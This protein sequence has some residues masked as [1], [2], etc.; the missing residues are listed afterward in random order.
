MKVVYKPWGKEEWLELNDHYCY[1][2]IYINA[3]FQTSYQYH[4]EKLETNYIAKGKAEVWLENEDGVVEKSI[5]TE[6]DTFTVIPPRKHRVVAIT[7]IILQEVS[8][9]Q[10]DDIVRLEDDTNRGG[11][12]LESEHI[13]PGVLI[14]AAGKGERLKSLTETINKAL[15][16]I[17]NEAIISKIIKKF[18][19]E[20]KFVITLGYKGKMIEN[21]LKIAFPL[22]DFE[23]V[24]VD[25]F[26]SAN[27]GPGYSAL[28]CKEF[29]QRPFYLVT[30]DCLI[31]SPLPSLSGN[32]LGVHPT[33]Y[34][35]KY[36]TVKFDD[37]FSI[38]EF[39]NKDINGFDY[40]FIGL[41]GFTDYQKFWSELEKN[42]DEGELVNSFNNP[43]KYNDFQAEVLDWFDTGNLD[44]LEKAKLYFRDKPL[45]LS[46]ENNEFVYKEDTKFIKFISHPGRLKNLYNRGLFLDKLIPNNLSVTDSFL[47]YDWVE[48]DTLY[49]ID[50]IEIYKKFIDDYLDSVELVPG[51][52]KDNNYFYKDKTFDRIKKFKDIYGNRYTEESFIINEVRYDSLDNLI[53]KIDFKI[54]E[55]H[56]FTNN[57]HGD[58]QFDNILYSSS[59]FYYVDWRDSFGKS[60]EA[61]DIYYDLSKL[62][63]GMIIP[64]NMMKD[65]NNIYF[66]E[67]S[68]AVNFEIVK[69]QKLDQIVNYYFKL[70]SNTEFEISK[71]KL[72]SSLIYLNMAPLHEEK[73]GK[74][75]WFNAISKLSDLIDK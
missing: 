72:I 67:N 27:S 15:I 17:N 33:G 11:G 59:K 6:G 68:L 36:S 7:D 30:V 45:S 46:K 34:P 63:G 57:F 42:I 71:I 56:K 37:N 4:E 26:E 65:E 13:K 5:K 16:P 18:P 48:G 40:A 75:L 2:R 39:L 9:P 35:E 12:R 62:Y 55:N 74:F 1:K 31:S 32:W 8:T 10:V 60:I 19:S 66:S 47:Y 69:N 23:F 49:N 70:L 73:F 25:D 52:K 41:A 3:G 58:L 21:Y 54:F 53:K 51:N 38:K 28:A 22:H 50:K 44:D 24:Y 64:Y 14:L 61:G 29:L 43:E 20:Y